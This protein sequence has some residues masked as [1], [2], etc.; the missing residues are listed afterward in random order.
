[1]GAVKRVNRGFWGVLQLRNRSCMA[2]FI[3]ECTEFQLSYYLEV[4]TP[5]TK[6]SKTK[7]LP[8]IR[9]SVCRTEVR[10]VVRCSE[11]E[12][13]VAATKLRSGRDA[14]FNA[15]VNWVEGRGELR[16]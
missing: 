14:D 1:M 7:T 15:V 13:T 11:D 12:V 2:G 4:Q 9:R 10:T 8:E 16:G 6:V 3:R 5:E